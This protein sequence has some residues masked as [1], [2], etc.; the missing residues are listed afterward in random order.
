MVTTEME[1]TND[2]PEPRL[3][4]FRPAAQPP[5][6][7]TG[8]PRF[9]LR[10]SRTDDGRLLVEAE[11]P[12]GRAQTVADLP[13]LV[14][15]AGASD[16]PDF[17]RERR[18]GV[19]LYNALFAP[20]ILRLLEESRLHAGE[21]PLPIDLTIVDQQ[22]VSLPWELLRDPETDRFLALSERAPLTRIAPPRPTPAPLLPLPA[23]GTLKVALIAQNLDEAE[24]ALAQAV[25]VDKRVEVSLAQSGG[26]LRSNPHVLQISGPSE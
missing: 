9:R 22:L 26:T 23:I 12:P 7:T 13:N 14:T 15:Q 20:H 11:G 16:Q 21:R 2:T 1:P 17:L 3:R 19:L 4:R 24:I 18:T 25:G 6:A 10:L 8:A 5:T